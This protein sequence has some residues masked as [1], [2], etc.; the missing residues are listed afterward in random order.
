MSRIL[1]AFEVAVQGKDAAVVNAQA[2]PH[3]IATLNDTVKYGDF[4]F[5][6]GQQRS[7]DVNEDILV[8]RIVFLKHSVVNYSSALM[9]AAYSFS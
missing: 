1:Q 8:F 5:L 2:F 6:T 7:I 3:G 4:G 9:A